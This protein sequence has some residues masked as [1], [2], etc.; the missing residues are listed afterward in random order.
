MSNLSAVEAQRMLTRRLLESLDL[1]QVMIRKLDGTVLFWSY[2]AELLYGWSAEEAIG[3]LS[4]DLLKTDFGTER[5]EHVNLLL[6]QDWQWIGELQHIRKDGDPIWVVSHWT[7]DTSD[8]FQFP[9]VI[10]IDQDITDLRLG[11]N[12]FRNL[13][14]LMPQLVWQISPSGR[15][16]YTN[17]WWREYCGRDQADITIYNALS[18][19]GHPD[20]APALL[21]GWDAAYTTG[22]MEPWE[23]RYLRHDGLYRWF[24]GQTVA[25]RNEAGQI[26]HWI[27]IATEIDQLRPM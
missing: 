27:M 24:A 14:E 21:S 2:G 1:A 5:L 11:D 7:L 12:R 16:L 19:F 8:L 10:Q 22:R 3:R 9:I 17:R 6:T 13:T 23:I 15:I 18:Q 26:I 4:H 25:V 20:D